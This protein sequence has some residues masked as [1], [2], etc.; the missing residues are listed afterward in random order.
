MNGTQHTWVE[1]GMV[2]NDYQDEAV[3]NIDGP[4]HAPHANDQRRRH[5]SEHFGTFLL[6]VRMQIYRLGMVF[7]NCYINNQPTLAHYAAI[8]DGLEVDGVTVPKFFCCATDACE[9]YRTSAELQEKRNPYVDSHIAKAPF[10]F[11]SGF[12]FR[13]YVEAGRHF[14]KKSNQFPQ[15][16]MFDNNHCAAVF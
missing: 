12:K 14:M 3:V 4:Q 2:C 9:F 15:P 5:D 8:P 16:I 11:Y 10:V 7:C 1:K 13:F 6:S